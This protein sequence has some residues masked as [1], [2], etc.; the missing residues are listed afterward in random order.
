MSNEQNPMI[1]N[2]SATDVG[3]YTLTVN[4]D[5][6]TSLVSA[7]T[8]VVMNTI[9]MIPVAVNNTTET[10]PACEGGD[11]MLET[12][13]I[14]GATY[15]WYGPNGYESTEFNPTISDATEINSGEYTVFVTMNGCTSEAGMTE[16]FVQSTP[17]VPIAT[18]SGPVC[19]TKC[20]KSRCECNV[21]LVR[22]ID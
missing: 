14:T 15:Q 2:L 10:A 6:C 4:V 22:F 8:S 12:D 16:A 11:L 9:P 13:F 17:N 5:G 1:E 19:N 21:H 18:N 7:A 3:D 20:C